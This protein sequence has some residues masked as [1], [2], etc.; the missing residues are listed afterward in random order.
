MSEHQEQC[1]LIAWAKHT[2]TLRQYPEL[3]LLF[4]VPNGGKRDPVTAMKMQ[5][6]GVVSGVPDL[7]L[8][9]AR[10]G[11]AGLWLE[12]KHGKNRITDNQKAFIAKLRRE[13]HHVEVCYSWDEA[14]T[15]IERYLKP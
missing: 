2:L 12:M 5:R 6:E 13:G 10:K 7:C 1:A 14:K 3:E 15:Q 11:F 9:V 8:P 4:A